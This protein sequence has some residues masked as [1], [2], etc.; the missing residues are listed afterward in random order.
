MVNEKQP[1]VPRSTLDQ[2]EVAAF[3]PGQKE[4]ERQILHMETSAEVMEA[5]VARLK[6]AR[7]KYFPDHWFCAEMMSSYAKKMVPTLSHEGSDLKYRAAETLANM[8]RLE[9]VMDWM[10]VNASRPDMRKLLNQQLGIELPI[11]FESM[12]PGLIVS[13][14]LGEGIHDPEAMA[15]LTLWSLSKGVHIDRKSS[16]TE[17]SGVKYLQSAS[18]PEFL[19]LMEPLTR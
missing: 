17:R 10:L 6:E 19:D 18:I 14:A 8:G 11:R 13:S 15:A 2:A 3:T 7:T 5:L 16:D 4:A 1:D 9:V 12:E